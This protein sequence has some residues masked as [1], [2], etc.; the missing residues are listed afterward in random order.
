MRKAFLI[1]T[2]FIS[3]QN[4]GD[5]LPI[6]SFTNKHPVISSFNQEDLINQSDYVLSADQSAIKQWKD[7]TYYYASKLRKC[8]YALIPVTL[9]NNTS[10]TLKYID[11]SCSTLDIFTT[12]TKSARI[13]QNL[14]DCFKNNPT[15]VTLAP[16]GSI[17]FDV[18]VYFFTDDTRLSR[19]LIQ[20]SFKLGVGLFRYT[21]KTSMFQD[22]SYMMTRERDN[23]LWSNAITIS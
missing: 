3:N 6:R 9:T 4:S 20:K 8:R 2:L 19:V 23:I 16:Y 13:F 1:I 5:C 18:P 17:K 12:D 14:K 7:T 21:D 22:I 10:D 11:M 15:I